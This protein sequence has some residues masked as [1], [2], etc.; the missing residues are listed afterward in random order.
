[1]AGAEVA[2]LWLLLGAELC[3]RGQRVRKRH[4]DGG[5]IELG[6]SPL[7]ATPLLALSA[8]GSGTG[9]V[10]ISPSV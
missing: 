5:W 1:M 8:V 4:P 3:A 9:I 7:I 6:S 10:L 2:Q